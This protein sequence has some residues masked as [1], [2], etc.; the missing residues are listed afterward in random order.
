MARIKTY[1]L[2]SE[3][4]PADKVVGTDGQVGVNLG[5]T[6]NYSISSLASYFSSG[7]GAA[8]ASAY[9]VWLDNGNT[10]TIQD[11]LDSL[12]GA[13]GSQGADGADGQQGAAGND[14]TSINIQGTKPTFNDLPGSGS[15]GD[16]W[17][18]DQTG[19]GATAGDGY[20][21]TAKNTWLNIGPLRGPQGVQG[22]AG[23]Q[24]IQGNQGPQ[25]NQGAQGNPGTNGVK[26]TEVRSV[27]PKI[28]DQTGSVTGDYAALSYVVQECKMYKTQ[29][30]DETSSLYT[31]SIALQVDINSASNTFFSGSNAISIALVDFSDTISSSY[32]GHSVNTIVQFEQIA[33]DASQKQGVAFGVLA[34]GA[35]H[36]KIVT[37]EYNFKLGNVTHPG[38]FSTAIVDD[39]TSYFSVY[40]NGMFA[41]S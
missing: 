7:E 2:D 33:G 25:G 23:G 8:G 31:F 11:F 3:I 32:N 24:G 9:Q 34:G 28:C 20:V 15:L 14:G 5:K 22:P 16:L 1:N 6:K 18:I 27:I 4:N 13:A 37:S 19:G 38:G 35:K 21:W 30:A 39:D 10:G 41:G 29:I 12:V 17:I 40:L 36:I 26:F